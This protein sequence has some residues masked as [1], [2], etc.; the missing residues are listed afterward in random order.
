MPLVSA[1]GA[2]ST[3]A[4]KAG[5]GTLIRAVNRLRGVPEEP[6]IFQQNL[7]LTDYTILNKRKKRQKCNLLHDPLHANSQLQ[8]Y[9]KMQDLR[10][11]PN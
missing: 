3:L 7:Q 6:R 1:F 9:N 11:G 5:P 10:D 8:R 2:N 4:P